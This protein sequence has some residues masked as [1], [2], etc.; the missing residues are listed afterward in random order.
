VSRETPDRFAAERD[1]MVESQLQRRGISDP[2]VLAAM[3]S[4]PREFFVEADSV[5][6]AYAD[7]PLPIAE[8][9]TISQPYIVAVMTQYL[10]L[11]GNDAALEIGTG[12]GYGAAVLSRIA[13]TVD[14]VE[15]HS[16]L[17]E[18]ARCRLAELGCANVTVHVGDGSLGLPDHGPFD[19]ISVTAAGP[20]IPRALVDQLADGGRLIM[21]VGRRWG[22][23]L[24]RAR[25]R[26]E[27]IREE[28]LEAVA[29]VP[30]VGDQGV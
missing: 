11:T 29:F 19:A 14:T 9:Q 22:Q 2:A 16:H 1:R 18:V 5:G 15:R 10:E 25:K 13:R 4:V 27:T 20:T 8:G 21:P 3:R 6:E 12:S 30:L 17:A 23:R 28:D 7:R 24:V 26:G